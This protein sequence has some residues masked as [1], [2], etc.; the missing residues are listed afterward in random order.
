MQATQSSNA[1]GRQHLPSSLIAPILAART[2]I[3]RHRTGD[4]QGLHIPQISQSVPS[5]SVSDV[6]NKEE[7]A[8]LRFVE[9]E[10]DGPIEAAADPDPQAVR[11]AIARLAR[12][13]EA[14]EL[15]R[16][17]TAAFADVARRVWT[18]AES[19]AEHESLI[20]A[21]AEAGKSS[22][23]SGLAEGEGLAHDA[24]NLFSALGL[25]SDLL[26]VPG[27]LQ[28]RHKHYAEDLKV[29][30]MRSQALIDR[31]LRL[32]GVTREQGDAVEP[33][34]RNEA[35]EPIDVPESIA[36]G[37]VSQVDAA[38]KASGETALAASGMVAITKLTGAVDVLRQMG[39]LLSTIA[40]GALKVRL[41]PEANALIAVD[42]E[43]L[44]RILVNLVC[45]ARS[46][47]CNGG[48]IR[49]SL[50][51]AET[52]D[53]GY[54]RS[55]A[56]RV[57]DSG[58]GMSEAQIGTAFGENSG[59][60]GGEVPGPV[61][62]DSPAPRR[63]HGMGLR[64]VRELVAVSGGRL[65]I[66][67]RQGAGTRIEIHW[68][69]AEPVQQLLRPGWMGVV[70][71]DKSVKNSIGVSMGLVNRAGNQAGSRISGEVRD[72]QGAIAC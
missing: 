36:A 15:Q 13:S 23:A 24:G 50:G 64:I 18:D 21:V 7:Y 10:S 69:T 45:N 49:I 47:I 25:Y 19:E 62:G 9:L 34:P 28:E 68:P 4:L 55:L 26:S 35:A 3:E 52:E 53:G 61:D 37:E 39:G 44:E 29:V 1:S 48:A 42:A 57:D 33:L 22:V 11:E 32:D 14:R 51:V 12:E 27:V 2:F 31:L 67:S 5:Q 38:A 20:K 70:A 17:Q 54:G 60:S 59:E 56:L 58:C 72:S 43:S 30:A 65:S 46:A 63:R 66:Q 71:L 16:P 41:G 6:E 8:E 40:H